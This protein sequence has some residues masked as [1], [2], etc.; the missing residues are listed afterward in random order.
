[1][2]TEYERYTSPHHVSHVLCGRRTSFIYIFFDCDF[3]SQCWRY[4]GVDYDMR[5]VEDAPGWLLHKLSNDNENEI[6]KICIILWGI[7]FSRNKRVWE[8]N[9]ISAVIAMGNS[10]SHVQEW[11]ATVSRV[12]GVV[13][14]SNQ[15][16]RQ[17]ASRW[18]P[19][20]ADV[21]KVNVDASFIS[22]TDNLK[23]GMVLRNHGGEFL[24]GRTSCFEAV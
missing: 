16:G 12:K 23:V 17:H 7:W 14:T 19:P 9:T 4:V 22:N 2:E 18:N 5:M 15:Q 10:F 24:A 3:A 6:T 13:Q 8:D 21:L 1:M 20:A 11:K